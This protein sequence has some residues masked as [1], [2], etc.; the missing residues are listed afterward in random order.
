MSLKEAYDMCRQSCNFV[1]ESLD[2]RSQFAFRVGQ[3]RGVDAGVDVVV[4]RLIGI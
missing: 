1:Q 3:V 4:Q 2:V